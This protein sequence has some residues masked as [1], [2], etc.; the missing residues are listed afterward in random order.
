MKHIDV[1]IHNSRTAE[2]ILN[3]ATYY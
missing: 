3:I 2:A 1:S